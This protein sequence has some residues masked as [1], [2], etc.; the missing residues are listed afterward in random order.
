MAE[1]ILGLGSGQASTLNQ[2]LIDKL[3]D[4]ERKAQVEPIEKDLEEIATEQEKITEII[5]LANTF[6]DAVKPF[7]LFVTSGTNAFEDKSATTSGD[8]VVFDAVDVASLNTGTTTVSVT[9]LAQR[10]V[11]QTNTF[12]DKDAVIT[13]D[14][15]DKITI[16]GTDF[17]IENK[18]YQELADAI[19]ADANFNATVEQVGTSSYRIVIKSAESGTANALTITQTG[20]DLGLN[21]APNHTLTAQNLVATVD[22]VAYDVSTNVI[23]VDGGLKITAVKAGDSTISVEKDTSQLTTKMQS[24][25]T[26]YNALV[27]AV[28]AELY[29]AETTIQD[30]AT[31][32]TMMSQIKDKLFGNYGASSDLNMFEYGFS[33]DKSGFLS[34][35][36]TTFN[37]A[38]EDDFDN[39]KTLFIGTAANEGLGTQLKTFVDS[40]DGFDGL[41][42]TYE[43][44]M[45]S[46]K[47]SLQ[48]EL[49]KAEETLNNKYDQLADQFAAY[50]SIITQFEAQFSGLKLLIAQSQAS[51]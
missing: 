17:T 7:D 26:G 14:A 9:T 39:L 38:V 51:N 18:T 46:R 2:E 1:G 5:G 32:R 48:E 42:T 21:D 36:T 13:T 49:K 6:L 43:T 29:S 50:G 15:G 11:Y 30:K 23:T 41:L 28:D 22:G 10:D 27:T 31:L 44:N 25:I 34:L 45:T 37:T 8:S 4:A 20:E 3:K 16:N 35:N 47:E 19:N 24:F 33:L 40:L 12:A